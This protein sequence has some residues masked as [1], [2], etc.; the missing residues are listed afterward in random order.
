MLL[1]HDGQKFRFEDSGLTVSDLES[2]GADITT[3]LRYDILQSLMNEHLVFFD[4]EDV[5]FHTEWVSEEQI[6]KSALSFLEFMIHVQ[7]FI[8]TTRS[9]TARTFKDDLIAALIERFGEDQIIL[10]EAPVASLSYYVVDIVVRHKSGR[11]A[12]IFPATSEAKALEAVLFSKEIELKNVENVIPFLIYEDVSAPRVSKPTQSKAMNSELQMADWGG[13]KL[14]VID[15]V[16]K[17][18]GQTPK[19]A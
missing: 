16:N 3:G 14:D 8:F 6:G 7:D 4:E 18:V 13:G 12:A 5:L 11:T 9:R 15:K 1:G 19:R 2:A 17:Y 10:L